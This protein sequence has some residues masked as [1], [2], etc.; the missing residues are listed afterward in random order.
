[1][2]LS[3]YFEQ[4]RDQFPALK[5]KVHGRDLVYLDSAATTLKPESVAARVYHFNQYEISNVHRGAHYLA[6]QATQNFE[7]ARANVANFLHAQTADE[8]IFVRG[9]TEAINLIAQSYARP[10]LKEGD[11]ILITE[12]EHHANIVPWHMVAEQT[13]AKVRAVLVK[14]NG[15]LDLADLKSKLSAKTKILAFTACSNLLGTVNDMKTITALAHKVGAKV[16]VDGAQ[17]VSQEEVNVQDIGCDF[18]AFSGHKL[19]APFGIGILYGKKEI[20][21]AMPPYQGG[22]SMISEVCIDRTSYN[23]V[24]FRFEAGTPNVEG[25]IGLNT[26]LEFVKG[27][28]FDKIKAHKAQLLKAATEG[29]LAI[30][31]VKI[32]G[33]APHKGPILSFNLEGAHHS[34]VGQI[35]DQQGVAVRAGHHCTQ[36]LMKRLGIPGTVRASFSV[37]N[38]MQDVESFLKSVRKAQELFQ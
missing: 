30:P 8:I 16:V 14:D 20:L 4:I 31:Q 28:G 11:E 9:T 21:E 3:K 15:E 19:F 35:M 7:A 27:I 36:P 33:L 37:Y 25:A 12:M 29:L 2:E 1:M 32:V 17:I 24:P 5:Q 38:N 26:A 10:L 23:D 6:D 18:F 13:Q 22:G 34:D